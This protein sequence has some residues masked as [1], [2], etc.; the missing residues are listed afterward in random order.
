[1]S[2][3]M[4]ALESAFDRVLDG[5]ENRA[6]MSVEEMCQYIA[7]NE[8]SVKEILRDMGHEVDK[9]AGEPQDLLKRFYDGN[10]SDTTTVNHELASEIEEKFKVQDVDTVEPSESASLGVFYGGEV[11]SQASSNRGNAAHS[12]GNQA[13]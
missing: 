10:P 1:M 7:D 13:E 3:P 4:P 9:S 8:Q 6:E 2:V 11:E 5:A 12:S